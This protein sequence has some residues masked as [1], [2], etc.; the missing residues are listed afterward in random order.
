MVPMV[1]VVADTD[2][3]TRT[4]RTRTLQWA[5]PN[6]K[7]DGTMSAAAAAAISRGA[8]P[9]SS[10]E[11]AAKAEANR[12]SGAAAR[13]AA[14]SPAAPASGGSADNAT[15]PAAPGIAGGHNFLGQ[16]DASSSPSDA[17]GAIGVTRYIQ[18]VN[19][20]FGIYNRT[21]NALVGSGTLSAFGGVAGSV[22]T[23][24]PQVIWD[25]TTSKFYYATAAIVSASDNRLLIGFSKNPSPNSEN[26]FCHYELAY[27]SL[28]PDFP[29]LGD[30]TFF[31]LVGVNAFSGNT[32]VGSDLLAFGKPST[33]ALTV[34]PT[35]ASLPFGEAIDLRDTATN[36]VFT[37]VPADGID[38]VGGVVIARNGSLPSTTLWFYTVGRNA[39]TGDPV[40]ST[41]RAMTVAEYS[42]PADATQG[43][44]SSRLI[45]TSD[46]RNTQAVLAR[47]PDRNNAFSFWTQHTVKEGNRSVVRWYEIDPLAATPVVRRTGTIGLSTPSVFFYN[48]AISPDRRVQGTTRTFGDNFVI[49]YTGSGSP[50]LNPTVAMASSVNGGPV[51]NHVLVQSAPGPYVDFTCAGLTERCRWGD[52]AG[53]NPDPNPGTAGVGAVWFTTQYGSGGT[54]TAQANW[55]TR[56]WAARP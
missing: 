12:E 42:L 1:P 23:F 55:L 52:Y 5:D 20:R 17:T 45:D 25:P 33:S 31:S 29:K 18:L 56:I 43:G 35:P 26:D 6:A 51:S 54:S 28:L 30:S 21:T 40:F 24:D 9:R 15:A 38:G 11:V 16:V 48:A 13:S 39:S 27:G 22:N 44:G 34:C 7:G 36:R 3:G 37:P 32:Y 50:S 47:N 10:Q 46:A 49:Q 53:A 4:E 41:A 19:R 14:M 2:N 8:L